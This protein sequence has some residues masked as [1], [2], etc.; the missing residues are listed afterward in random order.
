MSY[1]ITITFAPREPNSSAIPA[2]MPL[3]DPVT[4]ATFPSSLE[5]AIL[6]QKEMCGMWWLWWYRVVVSVPR[7]SRIDGESVVRD[8]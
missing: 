3:P 6:F 5:D 2:P 1:N 4:S 8:Q 7:L